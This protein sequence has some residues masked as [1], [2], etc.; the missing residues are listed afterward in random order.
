MDRVLG[1]L[2]QR[3]QDR[4]DAARRDLRTLASSTLRDEPTLMWRVR[5]L[6]TAIEHAIEALDVA[7]RRVYLSARAPELKQLTDPVAAASARG[8]EFVIVH[9]GRLP[10]PTPNGRTFLHGST[11]GS[12]YSAHESRHLVLATDT[13]TA[14]WAVARDGVHWNGL[15]GVDEHFASAVKAF[16]RH[17]VYVQRMYGDRRAELERHYGPGLV[18]L[19]D[20]SPV[21]VHDDAAQRPVAG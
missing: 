20:L 8:V 1:A 17:D 2:E 14:L 4:L 18:Q 10:F 12:P 11:Q 3:F 19:A 13:S 15:Y 6:P 9:F 16:I 5:S 21:Y 7:E